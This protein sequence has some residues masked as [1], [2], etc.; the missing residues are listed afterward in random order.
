MVTAISRTILQR[1]VYEVAVENIKV[2][3]VL[4]IFPCARKFK[5]RGVT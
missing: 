1:K 3:T 4:Y 5:V 2:G